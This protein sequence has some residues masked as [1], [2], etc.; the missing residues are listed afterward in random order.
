[1]K[2]ANILINTVK[3][4]V[5]ISVKGRMTMEDSQLFITE[6]NTKM[7]SIKASEY[8]LEVDCID[9]PV[10]TP[11]MAEELTG[12]MGLYKTTGFGKVVFQIKSNTVLKMQLSRLARNAGLSNATVADLA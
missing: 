6:Y 11:E 2:K 8:T 7:N 4:T 5:N 3:K 1:M 12:V 9:M 10:V